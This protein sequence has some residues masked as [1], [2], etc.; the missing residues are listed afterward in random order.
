MEWIEG[1]TAS[2]TK[3][4]IVVLS[5][6]PKTAKCNWELLYKR[7]G[8]LLTTLKQELY[9]IIPSL[10]AGFKL[11][12]HVSL[13]GLVAQKTDDPSI[14]IV[15]STVINLP[16]TGPKFQGRWSSLISSG[17]MGLSLISKL[18]NYRSNSI[19]LENQC[20]LE[21]MI[22]EN[23]IQHAMTHPNQAALSLIGSLGWTMIVAGNAV[24]IKKCSEIP[25]QITPQ[26]QCYTDI[27]VTINNTQ[28]LLFIHP[29][30]RVITK[31]SFEIISF[32]K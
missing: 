30:T 4:G 25:V 32:N 7:P 5:N 9:L 20:I 18:M 1:E 12:D 21:Y 27:P 28:S 31:S 23:I 26:S 22:R 13:C 6:N 29:I 15:N 19:L 14:F 3:D 8:T 24:I 2:K 17:I 11:I 16:L 10:P